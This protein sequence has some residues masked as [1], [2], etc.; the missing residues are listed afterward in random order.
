MGR[1]DGRAARSGNRQGARLK[2]VI[3]LAISP[4]E[5]VYVGQARRIVERWRQH[6]SESRRGSNTYFHKAMRK[7]GTNNFQV[8][9]V[10]SAYDQSSL[11]NLERLWIILL[12]SQDALFGYNQIAGGQKF[13]G[14]VWTAEQRAKLSK[15]T[16]GRKLA[17]LTEKHKERLRQARL[18]IPCPE[19]V[20]I[21]NRNRM[22]GVS[23]PMSEAAKEKLSKF[24][25]GR[26][27]LVK[28]TPEQK[29]KV[30]GDNHWR[31]RLK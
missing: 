10:S 8:Q 1:N 9:L 20:K 27:G 19:H 7:H 16:K 24:F 22:L 11:D 18:G 29:L 25:T 23:R 28:W 17:P 31:K 13:S 30:S 3:Y 2:A 6:V 14:R 5:K 21:L 15:S 4:S 26:R 12:R